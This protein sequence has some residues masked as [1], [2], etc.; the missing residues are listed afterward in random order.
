MAPIPHAKINIQ[1]CAHPS[2]PIASQNLPCSSF[3][4]R[5]SNLYASSCMLVA[6]YILFMQTYAAAYFS[7][8]CTAC[9]KA[10]LPSSTFTQFPQAP[11]RA[12][13]RRRQSEGSTF[14]ITPIALSKSPARLKRST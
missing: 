11:N 7:S 4:F 9:S 2:H 12:S 14:S 1:F 3:H 10:I 6:A 8:N 13:H 5:A